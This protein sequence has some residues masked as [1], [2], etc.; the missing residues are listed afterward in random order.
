MFKKFLHIILWGAAIVLIVFSLG[1][2]ARKYRQ[3]RCVGLV[4]DVSDSA[5]YRF[6]D[7]EDV[8]KWIQKKYN[9][10]FGKR[11]DSINTRTIEEGLEKL[12]A[13]GRAQVY[14]TLASSTGDKGGSLVVRIE[15]RR[16]YSEFLPVDWI[17]IWTTKET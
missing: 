6:I 3:T 17:T 11:L 7:N 5:Q 2:S 10:V 8:E 13:I 14:T 16:L 4:V 1:F 9:G 15:Q 12:Q